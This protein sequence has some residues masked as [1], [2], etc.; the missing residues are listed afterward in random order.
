MVIPVSLQLIPVLNLPL[1][2]WIHVPNERLD[3]GQNKVQTTLE[4]VIEKKTMINLV[5][6]FSVAIKVRLL[7]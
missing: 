3:K 7:L 4:S 6:A 2:I 1:Q 5:Q